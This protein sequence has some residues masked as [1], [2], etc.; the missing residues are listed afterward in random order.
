MATEFT[1]LHDDLRAVAADVLSRGA[2]WTTL[3]AAGWAGLEVPEELGGSGAGFAEVAVI[4]EE[5]GRAAASTPYLGGAVLSVALL[6]TVADSAVRDPLLAGIADGTIR[7]TAVLGEFT[8]S[9][10]GRLTGRAD[11]VPDAA[12]A[13]RLLVAATDAGGAD[14][15]VVADD[16]TVSAQPLL[17]ETR[18]VATVTADGVEVD[19]VL[20]ANRTAALGNRAALAVACDSLGLAEAMLKATVSYAQTRTQFGRPIGSFQAVKHACADMLVKNSVARALIRE[21]IDAV[22]ADTDADTAVAMAKSYACGAA[23]DVVGKAMQLHGGIGYTWESGIH[24]YLKRA[25]FNRSLF[26]SPAAHRRKLAH[27]YQ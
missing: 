26:G 12:G 10:D 22:L 15:V 20:A 16:L 25:T 24:V 4:C 1:E 13:D 2:D 17:D 21:A 9:A 7:A 18:S 19:A 5:L 23:V 3:V 14:V 8:V 11:F 6:N 27:R